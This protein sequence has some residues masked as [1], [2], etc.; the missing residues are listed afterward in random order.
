MRYP[1]AAESQVPST[2]G[3]CPDRGME[4]HV[5]RDS[6]RHFSLGEPAFIAKG[7]ITDGESRKREDVFVKS[8][9]NFKDSLVKNPEAP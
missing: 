2:R 8:Q 5:D 3:L 7:Y 4:S 6:P 9:K 1:S